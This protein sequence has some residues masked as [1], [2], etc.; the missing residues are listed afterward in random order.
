MCLLIKGNTEIPA[1]SVING[2]DAARVRLFQVFRK[3]S[4]VICLLSPSL[5]LIYGLWVSL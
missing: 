3:S 5:S 1:S 2:L 4:L